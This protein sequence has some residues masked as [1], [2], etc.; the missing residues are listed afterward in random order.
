MALSLRRRSDYRAV[1]PA[2]AGIQTT[3]TKP[4]T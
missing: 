1:I 2:K 3:A 4:A